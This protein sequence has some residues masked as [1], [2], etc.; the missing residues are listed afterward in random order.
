MH[1]DTPSVGANNYSP[2]NKIPQILNEPIFKRAFSTAELASLSPEQ[3]DRYEQSLKHYRDFKN[4]IDTAVEEAV[5][6]NRA[7][8]AQKAIKSG[9]GDALIAELTGLDIAQI[10]EL[11][12]QTDNP[13]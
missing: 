8:T 9:L 13:E 1:S 12:Q 2:F 11:R 4:A 5:E 3:R 10:Q 7:S 6:K